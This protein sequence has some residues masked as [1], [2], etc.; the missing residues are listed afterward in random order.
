M[1]SS[2]LMGGEY[3]TGFCFIYNDGQFVIASPIEAR[4]TEGDS[5][6]YDRR[7]I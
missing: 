6:N 7:L 2:D 3:A 4:M 1:C 5:Y